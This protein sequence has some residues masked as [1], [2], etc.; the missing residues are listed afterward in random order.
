MPSG[1][2]LPG[3]AMKYTP[4]MFLFIQVVPAF[5]IRWKNTQTLS[6][7]GMLSNTL[8]RLH[9]KLPPTK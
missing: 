9:K 4:P 8:F 5:L 2:L 7:R 6:N 3:N 1:G